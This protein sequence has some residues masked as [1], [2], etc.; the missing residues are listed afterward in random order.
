MSQPFVLFDVI[1]G[2]GGDLGIVTLNRPQALNSLN[3]VMIQSLFQHLTKWAADKT[4]KAVVIRAVP[5]RAFCAGGDIKAVY[6]QMKVQDYSCSEFFQKEYELNTLIHFYPK[7]YI[8]L[9]DGITMGGGAG[10][11]IHGSHRIATSRLQF[12]MPETGIGFFPDVGGTY[13]LSRLAHE[14]GTYLGLTGA[15]INVDDCKTLGLVTHKVA[16]DC[17]QDLL[18]ALAQ[19]PFTE[20]ANS[21]IDLII[22]PFT[23]KI[24]PTTLAAEKQMIAD[25][26]HADEI[27]TILKALSHSI[28]AS[29]QR[30]A[31]ML[32]KK[33]PTSLHITLRALRLARSIDFKSCMRQEYRLACHLLKSYDFA[34]GIRAAVIDKDQK[35]Q[36]SPSLHQPITKQ[37]IENYFKPL[38]QELSI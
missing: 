20:Q 36:W 29:M 34:E 24:E 38:P 9:L 18:A 12:A 21:V 16:E 3:Y 14:W 10:I 8:A 1:P 22:A 15:K 6:E 26:F 30:A 25:C 4:I 11:S 23:V 28:H 19:T 33:S 5:G 17:F 37:S 2:I 32:I 31:E 7:P 35:P 27:E 13:F